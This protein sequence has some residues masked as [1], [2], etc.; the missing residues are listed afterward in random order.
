MTGMRIYYDSGYDRFTLDRGPEFD[1]ESVPPGR[2]AKHLDVP[3]K[4][5]NHAHRNPDRWWTLDEVPE[6][7][8]QPEKL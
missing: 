8:S 7:P 2:M 4:L 5:A 1:M 3:I 6:A